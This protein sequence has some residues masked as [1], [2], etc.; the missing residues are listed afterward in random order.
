VTSVRLTVNRRVELT[1]PAEPGS[2]W[3]VSGVDNT[4]PWLG[5]PAWAIAVGVPVVS[6]IGWALPLFG[7]PLAG[8]FAG[9]CDRGCG[10][11]PAG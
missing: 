1:V 3:T 4:W 7:V 9:R 5:L 2:A 6:A 8:V 11:W 10:S